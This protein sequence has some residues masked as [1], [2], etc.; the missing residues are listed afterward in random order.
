MTTTRASSCVSARRARVFCNG[1]AIIGLT[2]LYL[3]SGQALAAGE[4]RC[5]ISDPGPLLVG[6]Q[7]T[8]QGYV[9]GNEA[10]YEVAWSSYPTAY[11]QPTS[12]TLEEAG[13]TTSTAKFLSI[14][15]K[16]VQLVVEGTTTTCSATLPVIVELDG[17]G[18]PA[19]LPTAR[20]DTYATPV[21]K[22]LTVDRS[23]VSGV[24][25]NDFDTDVDGNSI[26][27][28]WLTAQLVSAPTA[29]TVDLRQDG[30]FEYVPGPMLTDNS[31]DSFTYQA[32]DYD[33][34]VSEETTVNIH[35]L[36]DQPD[37]KIMMNY[38][39][40]MHCTG[41]EFSYCC[42]LPPY[43]SI[44]AQVVKPQ[45][46][47]EPQSS[48]DFARLLEGDP[49]NGLDL[50][51]RQT[52]LRDYDGDGNIQKY[53]L[54]YSHDAQPRREGN[55]QTTLQQTST[56]IS[57][58]EGNSLL[59][60]NTPFD[61]A[62]VDANGR[63]VRGTYNGTDN[64]VVGD[65]DYLDPTDN[66]AN[67]WLNHLY[68]YSGLEGA[69]LCAAGD[70]GAACHHDEDC[71]TAPGAGNG[72]CGSSAESDK[73]RLGVTGHVEYPANVG[74]ALQ[75]MGPISNGQPSKDVVGFDNVLTF[76][77]EDG[78]IV[79]TQAKVLENLPITLTSPG[80]WEALGLP[81]TPFEDTINF[82]AEPGAVDED[83]IRPFV[84]MK[85]QLHSANCDEISGDCTKGPAVIGSNGLPVIGF[86]AAPIDIPNCER[87]H[88][89]PAYQEDGITP[90]V[91]SPSYVRRQDG[92]DPF[93]YPHAGPYV[94]WSLEA[95]TDLEI[96]YWKSIYPSLTTG[97]DWYARLKGA[98]VNM[99][100]VHDLDNGTSFLANYPVADGQNP[101]GL[102][103][104][105]NDPT[106]KAGILQNTRMGEGSVICQRC[107]GDN[108]IAAVNPLGPTVGDDF[109]PPISEAIHHA[110]R[111]TSDGGPIEFDDSFGRFGGCQGCH[112]AHRSDGVM[113]N[114][115]ITT[116][117]D[118]ANADGDNRL[119]GGG[120]F[121]GRDVHSNALK[122]LDGAETPSHLNAVGEWLYY[123]VAADTG[124]WRG[125]WCTNCHNQLSQEIWKTEDCE[126]LING[127]CVTNPRAAGPDLEDV[128]N[129]VGVSL[130]QAEMWLD[131]KDP[132][133]SPILPES[134]APRT[135][136]E[137]MA[138]WR[139]DPGLCEFLVDPQAA[140][141]A[142]LATVEVSIQ[143][144]DG[145]CS[146][147][148][149]LGP[150]DCSG[151][152]GPV[153][154]LCGIYD[155]DPGAAN[156]A[157][158]F[159]ANILDFCTTPDCV[160]AAQDTL[161][162]T[163]A[164]AVPF[165]AATDGRDHWLAAGEPHCADCH[166]APFVEQSG[167]ISAYPPFNYPRKASLS[168]YTRGH[169]GISCQ[170]CH[171]SIHG[172]YPVGPAMDTTS[173][174]QAAAL[175]H[176]GSHGPLKCGAC[177]SVDGQGI[178]TWI[179]PDGA[180][181]SMFDTF[182]DAV[183][184]AHTYTEEADVRDSTCQNCHQDKAVDISAGEKDYLEHSQK[185]YTSRLMMDKAEVATF[186]QVLGADPADRNQ[187]C[188]SCHGGGNNELGNVKCNKKWLQHLTQGRVA[189]SVWED[190]SLNETG[191]LCGW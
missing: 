29:G 159:S 172:L 142:T 71:D 25:Y 158:D 177:H 149:S 57:D 105:V 102:P 45:T 121:V 81:L 60:H 73:L 120:C 128:A 24:L 100:A 186:G 55:V 12:G 154:D 147:G 89:A 41:F 11:L 170:G 171:E 183:A 141:D 47:G 77:G 157:G 145:A 103:G 28:I 21:G 95:I 156:P 5:S 179:K 118:N 143:G 136:N 38:E 58:V 132:A 104:D 109:L 162:S 115:P 150:V 107:H 4:L 131:P 167:N 86:G 17:T 83:A 14:G 34:N 169:Q 92:D 32:R 160:A 99:L 74:A 125:I 46:P 180:V 51:G 139:E 116:S 49:N 8:L 80:I 61:S 78:T 9:S 43:N 18:G 22:T 88:A 113:D 66:F 53:Y 76:S 39:L 148:Q 16:T 155:G 44:V 1:S 6:E 182:D 110:H 75:P 135:A 130:A 69:R 64:V 129:A 13:Q 87:C 23:R 72:I 166:A 2:A 31:N 91:N 174:A 111:P 63:L 127:D 134:G 30:S 68:I 93:D 178:P 185:G 189:E 133:V 165:S 48:A 90:N 152:G 187:L 151:A 124:S 3:A 42:I 114:Y 70:V 164:V 190:V 15:I 163:T 146:T 119:G 117:G 122:D 67:G 54:E 175:N 138:V 37:F 126:D 137:T 96:N 108:V 7:I 40:G 184:W 65:G 36:S 173:Y 181:G 52:V 188:S 98:A 85:A 19:G 106:T 84:A 82:F 20:G 153:F 26:G 79:Y 94:G 101:L 176:D 123:N 191:G 10:P 168:R 144:Q 97:T 59:Y 112:P 35:I 140:H 50:L 161:A 33:G 62:D 27:N 56:L